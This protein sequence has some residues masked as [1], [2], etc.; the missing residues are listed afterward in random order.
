MQRLSGSQETNVSSDVEN[1]SAD[2]QDIT[3]YLTEL[4]GG[5]LDC[6]TEQT[7]EI[8]VQKQLKLFDVE[9]RQRHDFDVW[10][11]WISRKA[12]HPQL[13]QVAL[14]VLATPS[15]QVSVERS[16]SALRLVLSD[17]R[18]M[19]SDDTLENILILKLNDDVFEEVFPTMYDWKNFKE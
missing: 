19:M 18:T 5:K 17:H 9:P 8:E 10:N 1:M 11:H 4:Y 3:D 2:D 15:S 7:T 14:V 6:H 16:F 12:S 13:A